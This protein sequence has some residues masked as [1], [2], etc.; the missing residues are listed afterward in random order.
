M[1]LSPHFRRLLTLALPVLLPVS[2]F[3]AERVERKAFTIQGQLRP[4]PRFS[5][6]TIAAAGSTFQ[7]QSPIYWDGKFKFKNV[8]PG[9]Y[10]VA[11]HVPR[12][13]E[14]RQTYSV[15]PSTADDKGRVKISILVHP[16]RA[17]KVIT[18]KD[19]FT[20]SAAKLSIPQSAWKE[21]SSAQRRIR[22]ND[23]AGAERHLKKAV[24]IAPQFSNAWNSL[25]TLSYGNKD[26]GK[27]AAHFREAIQVD[28]DA[29]EPVVNL[30]GALLNLH[31]FE[32]ALKLN[33]DAV[34]RRPMDALANVQLG[35]N[36]LEL[37][38]PDLALK[39]LRE[40]KRLDPGHFANPQMLLYEIYMKK[41]DR[42]AAARELESF[43]RYHP[44]SPD[45]E[46][47]RNSARKLRA[48]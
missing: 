40:A 8:Q 25:G 7:A 35:A 18:P 14:F 37:K 19:R 16:S 3:A 23:I 46:R 42:I 44:D 43:L 11:V 28:P 48:P 39:Y 4:I 29:Y 12:L 22:K 30:G 41:G 1:S 15:G 13:G 33:E 2:F 20:V 26:Y 45:A 31:Q 24:E 27:A 32:E 6:V 5:T 21:Y 17:S 36:Y 10:S 38:N 47:L 9:S 34:R